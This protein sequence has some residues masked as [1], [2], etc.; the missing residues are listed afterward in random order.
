MGFGVNINE[1]LIKGIEQSQ[2]KLQ[3]AMNNVY[4][5]LA[6]SANKSQANQIAQ[7]QQIINQSSNIDLSTLVAAITQLASRPVETIINME[8]QQVA[9][10]VTPFVTNIMGN[11]YNSE[12]RRSGVK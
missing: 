5:S 3:G 6:S 7:Q 12:L 8:G 1:G 4:G 10:A 9:R 11:N 2:N